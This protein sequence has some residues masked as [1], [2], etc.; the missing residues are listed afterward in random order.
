MKWNEMGKNTMQITNETKKFV[1]L[2]TIQP[3]TQNRPP[4]VHTPVNNNHSFSVGMKTMEPKKT[5]V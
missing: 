1:L 5:T 2:M 4:N 3:H